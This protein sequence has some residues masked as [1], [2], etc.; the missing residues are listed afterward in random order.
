VIGALVRL[1]VVLLPAVIVAIVAAIV[2][3]LVPRHGTTTD[4]TDV[5]TSPV[6]YDLARRH[7][8]VVAAVAWGALV[9][10]AAATSAAIPVGPAGGVLLGC[11]PAAAGLVF[12]LA[13]A[14]GER[15]WPSPSGA[16][17][18]ASLVRRTALD[19]GPRTLRA[20]LAAWSVTLLLTL[21]ATALTAGA[22]GRSFELVLDEQVHA[23]AGPYPGARY[24]LPLAL[25]TLL[26]IAATVGVLHLVARR[27]TVDG[28]SIADDGALRSA[29]AGRVLAGVQ[30]VVGATLAGVLL[31]AGQALRNAS[32]V[33]FAVDDVWTSVTDPVVATLGWA[34]LAASPVVAVTAVAVAA[35]GLTRAARV[36][37][38]AVAA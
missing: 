26:V 21:L 11:V 3:A 24:A 1:A 27:P 25:G 8:A 18:R 16:L 32:Q 13:A 22:D 28:V 15:T 9:L 36:A 20:V 5:V 19:V 2:A 34:A 14:V 12:L 17:R 37:T 33:S 31:F 4:T 30:L 38:P 10:V 6:A 35:V 29:S 7:A 23:G